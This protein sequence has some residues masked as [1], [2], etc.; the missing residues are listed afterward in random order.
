MT[1]IEIDLKNCSQSLSVKL[2][3][4]VLKKFNLLLKSM[5]LS[6]KWVIYESLGLR[7][8][9]NER[10]N[11][12]KQ[13]SKKTPCRYLFF[14]LP[15]WEKPRSHKKIIQMDSYTFPSKFKR[16]QVLRQAKKSKQPSQILSYRWA[17]VKMC[18]LT[19]RSTFWI[20]I[21][22]ATSIYL[23]YTLTPKYW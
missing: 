11:K 6:A 12:H 4:K 10:S 14:L 17:C 23:H 22:P 21:V 16:D 9:G 15:G 13:A 20:S 8:E 3:M 19:E 18:E 2:T 1:L 5:Q 7:R